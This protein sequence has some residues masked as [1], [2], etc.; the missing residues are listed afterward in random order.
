MKVIPSRVWNE[1]WTSLCSLWENQYICYILDSR[2]SLLG[3]YDGLCNCPCHNNWFLL[4]NHAYTKL[5]RELPVIFLII[6]K[7][8]KNGMMKERWKLWLLKW[9]L[10]ANSAKGF[11]MFSVYAI[12]GEFRLQSLVISRNGKFWYPS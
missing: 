5:Q 9:L 7:A 8:V 1:K 3:T 4:L 11:F 2:T 6:L 12:S 10:I